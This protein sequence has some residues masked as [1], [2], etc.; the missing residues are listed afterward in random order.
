MKIKKKIKKKKKKKKKI[1]II[2]ILLLVQLEIFVFYLKNNIGFG[3]GGDS[4][5]TVSDTGNIRIFD[6]NLNIISTIKIKLPNYLHNFIV[7]IFHL[8]QIFLLL[9]MMIEFQLL[10][11]DL[12]ISFY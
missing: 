2:L 12:I 9:E 7:L 10:L 3:M 8:H 6:L 5:I 4:F 1:I 11:V